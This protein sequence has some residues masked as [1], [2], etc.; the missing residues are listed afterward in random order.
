[1]AS[2][3]P[4][5]ATV[6]LYNIT[7]PITNDIQGA[8]LYVGLEVIVS[9]L[10]RRFFGNARG[11]MELIFTHTL[12]LPFL[13]PIHG[14][15]AKPLKGSMDKNTTADYAITDQLMDGAMGVPAVLLGEYILETFYRGI[16]F[17]KLAIREIAV[18]AGS[19]IITRPISVQLYKF[20]PEGQAASM[21][22]MEAMI[23]R[24]AIGSRMAKDHKADKDVTISAATAK[25]IAGPS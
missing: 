24:Q 15:I 5:A 18:T 12:S 22:L 1:M 8:V 25:A 20:I 14:L 3:E 21:L 17:P 23:A 4:N 7:A 2:A 13:G 11:W 10:I 6:L 19:K 16:H 9:K